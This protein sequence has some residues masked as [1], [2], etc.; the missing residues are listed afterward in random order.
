MRR[1]VQREEK[2]PSLRGLGVTNNCVE[3]EVVV[4][5]KSNLHNQKTLRLL[6]PGKVIVA[7]TTDP[8]W[9]PLIAAVGKQGGLVT[10]VG[11]L[12]AH[13]AL[14]SREVGNAAMMDVPRATQRL[15]TGMHVRVNGP[16]GIVEILKQ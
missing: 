15:H 14:I 3:G 2:C 12:L 6:Q 13:N 5:L 1:N 10:E 7:E 11:G 8:T 16:A 9:S 4:I